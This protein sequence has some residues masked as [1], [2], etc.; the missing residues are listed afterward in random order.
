MNFSNINYKG[1]TFYLLL[2]LATLSVFIANSNYYVSLSILVLLVCTVLINYALGAQ[3]Y[4][5]LVLISSDVDITPLIT[6]GQPIINHSIGLDILMGS[7]MLTLLTIFILSFSL[8]IIPAY[9]GSLRISKDI[10]LFIFFPLIIPFY[11][12]LLNPLSSAFSDSSQF[13]AFF[14]GFIVCLLANLQ[15]K[16]VMNIF[17]MAI[18][19]TAIFHI[20]LSISHHFQLL[21]YGYIGNTYPMVIFFT[22][23]IGIDLCIFYGIL[24][25][26]SLVIFPGRSRLLGYIYAFFSKFYTKNNLRQWIF[27]IVITTLIIL[28]IVY[29]APLIPG[30]RGYFLW[31]LT[32]IRAN[33]Y[34]ATSSY[35]RLLEFKNILLLN[36]TNIQHFFIGGGY[37]SCFSDSYYKFPYWV[38]H[39][40]TSNYP[41]LELQSDCFTKP[42]TNI[43]VIMLKSG[44]IL[45]TIF[46]AANFILIFIKLKKKI[47]RNLKINIYKVLYF[48]PFWIIVA[49]NQNSFIIYG[50]FIYLLNKA[51]IQTKVSEVSLS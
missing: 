50:I 41:N 48:T 42:H 49:Y 24:A 38:L 15:I 12:F 28:V 30:A 44:M 31:K 46:F 35:I 21:Y 4:L 34:N 40:G 39:S 10:L 25:A 27:L 22:E 16:T 51:F 29:V 26:L 23:Y 3:F 5:F 14:T 13:I 7:T 11:G 36:L 9:K 45:S 18:L 20:I 43:A 37:G 33:S 6:Y 32:T 47:A 8:L 1:K 2:I 17:I 19:S